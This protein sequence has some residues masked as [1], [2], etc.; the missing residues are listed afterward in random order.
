[1]KDEVGQT[2]GCSRRKRDSTEQVERGDQAAHQQ[3]QD[4]VDDANDQ[5]GNQQEV[6]AQLDFLVTYACTLSPEKHLRVA[7][8]GALFRLRRCSNEHVNALTRFL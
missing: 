1:M 2:N 6:A 7:E 8:T 4:H 5:D 3:R